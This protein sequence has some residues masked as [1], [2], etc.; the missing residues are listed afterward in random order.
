MRK[1]S[2]RGFTLV[3]LLVVI[4]II[5]VL[6]SVLLPA[7][8]RARAEANKIKCESNMR[9]ILQS[10][11][12][13]VSENKNTLPSP[14]WGNYYR[15]GWLY[16]SQT[17]T[18]NPWQQD[19]VKTGVLWTYMK[20]TQIFHCPIHV[21]DGAQGTEQLTSY[22][23]NGA[24]IAYGNGPMQNGQQMPKPAFKITKFRHP[25]D[26][27]L[28][29]E[30]E[31]RGNGT[32]FNGVAW[33]DGSSFPWENRLTRRHG[34]GACVGCFD[35]HVEWMEYGDFENEVNR[36][37]PTRLWCNPLTQDGGPNQTGH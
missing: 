17:R 28:L 15:W 30:A 18:G 31:E 33:N 14:D 3:E 23:M 4:G 20:S 8:N 10:V 32:T 19:D 11:T 6:I 29:W 25:S 22:L 5:A 34:R 1:S 37:G 16:D 7:L 9:T 2:F 24:V 36:P 27:I 26:Q 12:M 21:L 13:Y 35:S